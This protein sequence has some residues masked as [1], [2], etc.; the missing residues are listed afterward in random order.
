M[1]TE[2]LKSLPGVQF[3]HMSGNRISEK[4]AESLLSQISKSAKLIDLS[5]NNVGKLGVDHICA[6][7]TLRECKIETLNLEDNKLGDKISVKLFEALQNNGTLKKLNMSKNFLTDAIAD[8]I[9]ALLQ[10][11]YSIQELYLHWNLFKTQGGIK[12]FQGILENEILM[13]LD[14][15]W[16][17]I[18]NGV[19]SVVPEILEVF[20]TNERL[21]HLDLSNNNFSREESRQI[22]EG[23]ANN[24]TIYG[25]HFVGTYGHVD[26]RG[27]LIINE[28]EERDL[29]EMHVS[30]RI[31]SNIFFKN[32]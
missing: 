5:S 26:S 7:V 10:K 21:I 23:L 25:F 16:N 27:F 3:F 29:S 14:F 30:H 9:K 20:K 22:A 17:S 31:N 2:G 11:N 19:P 4:G 8:S 13:V 24:H 32:L 1:I 6:S 15:S 18:G 28:N 12:I